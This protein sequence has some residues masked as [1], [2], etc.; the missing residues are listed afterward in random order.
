MSGCLLLMLCCL[1][2]EFLFLCGC[3]G[4]LCSTF[5]LCY[6]LLLHPCSMLC[7]CQILLLLP[8]FLLLLKL[9]MIQIVVLLR[10][11][12]DQELGYG[13]TLE[14]MG[15]DGIQ[16]S[17]LTLL[18]LYIRKSR[19]IQPRVLWG[20]DPK[21]G[22]LSRS[23]THTGACRTYFPQP[24][25]R[26]VDPRS[27][28][29]DKTKG[30][31]RQPELGCKQQMLASVHHH[32]QYLICIYTSDQ[33]WEVTPVWKSTKMSFSGLFSI[34]T[35]KEL[36]VLDKSSLS[37]SDITLTQLHHIVQLSIGFSDW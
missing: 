2:S 21:R 36:S 37:I 31:I 33:H 18:V 17:T 35:L 5:G 30:L 4:G 25:T 13:F 6:L 24:Q 1:T 28:L 27:I 16:E 32:I 34:I 11:I 29:R 20:L 8:L 9:I 22:A 10:L 3:T 7:Q 19:E 12:G 14:I 15:H 26:C 23:V